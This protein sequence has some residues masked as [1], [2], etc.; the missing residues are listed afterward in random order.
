[1]LSLWQYAEKF[2]YRVGCGPGV[3]ED[4]VGLVGAAGE[5]VQ[6]GVGAVLRHDVGPAP[7]RLLAPSSCRAPHR[8]YQGQR[9]PAGSKKYK[10]KKI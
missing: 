2:I 6:P 1:M 8:R 3:P 9:V 10:E 4:E 7:P 5:L